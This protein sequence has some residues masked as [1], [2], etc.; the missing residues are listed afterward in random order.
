MI[1]KKKFKKVDKIK[2]LK[3]FFAMTKEVII[4]TCCYK[5]CVLGLNTFAVFDLKGKK[6]PYEKTI[7]Y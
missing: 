1:K 7:C 6:N 3:S 2:G 4:I 5:A